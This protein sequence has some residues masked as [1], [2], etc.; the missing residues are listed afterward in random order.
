M[1]RRPLS[2]VTWARMACFMNMSFGSSAPKNMKRPYPNRLDKSIS[3]DRM[4]ADLGYGILL[5]TFFVTLY[6]I[7]AA[8]YGEYDKSAALVESARRAMLL[9]WPLLTL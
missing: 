9:T 7:F 2:R 4:I 1:K 3:G 8:I 5:V 6:S